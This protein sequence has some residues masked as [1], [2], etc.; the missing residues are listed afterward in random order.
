MG[1]QCG[2]KHP[3]GELIERSSFTIAAQG[4]ISIE[5]SL[6]ITTV[7]K[8][9][10]IRISCLS[11]PLL[12]ALLG[13]EYRNCRSLCGAVVPRAASLHSGQRNPPVLEM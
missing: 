13:L 3:F 1:S 4:Q 5:D 8:A 9:A 7:D 11:Q 10:N 6:A 2:M 12:S